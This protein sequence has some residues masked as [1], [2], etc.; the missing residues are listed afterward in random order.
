MT[1]GFD[2]MASGLD[3]KAIIDGLVAIQA[4][5]QVLLKRKSSAASNLVSALQSLNTKVASLATTAAKAAD[6]SSA[7]VTKASTSS[8]D[9][10]SVAASPSAKPGAV[11]FTV[12]QLATRQVSL[13]NDPTALAGGLRITVGD[14]VHEIEPASE[15]IDDIAAAINAASGETGVTATKLRTTDEE[16]NTAYTL[17]LSG[18]TGAANAFTM[19]DTDGVDIAVTT[20]TDADDA[21]IT[22]WP[23]AGGTL[24]L[25]SA[26]NTFTDVLD[27][28]DITATK[29]TGTDD[30][31]VTVT[32]STDTAA[33]RKLASDLVSNLSVVLSDIASRTRTTT[34]TNDAGDTVV[35]GGLFSGDSAIRFLTSDLQAAMTSPVDGQSPSTIGITI[36]RDGVVSL[37]ESTFSDALAADPE[38]TMATLQAIAA[39]VGEVAERASDPNEGTLSNKISSQ[40]R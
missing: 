30:A 35:T 10:A 39:R 16:G 1:I 36:D 34:D 40:E 25:K 29:V 37:A 20:V 22:L 33:Q 38:K 28:V 27:G 3:T 32:V 2:G 12:D 18:A 5:Q 26:T 15:H 24:Q 31:P 21:Q 7:A 4:N 13:I 14:E 8:A 6:P 11:E 19:Q 17:Q 23:S 9:T